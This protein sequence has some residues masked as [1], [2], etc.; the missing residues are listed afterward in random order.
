M[1]RIA[2]SGYPRYQKSLT[3]IIK[4]MV[5]ARR[6]S[7]LSR[8]CPREGMVAVLVMSAVGSFREEYSKIKYKKEFLKTAAHARFF[9]IGPILLIRKRIK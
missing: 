9:V 6:I 8:R 1:P 5:R 7:M 2:A 4:N 3:K